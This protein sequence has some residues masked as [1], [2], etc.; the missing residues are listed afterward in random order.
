MKTIADRVRAASVETMRAISCALIVDEAVHRDDVVEFAERRIEHIA[1]GE[2]RGASA[3][4]DGRSFSR[5]SD[6]RRRNIDADDRR[7]PLGELERERACPAAGVE[8]ARAPGG[9][10]AANRESLRASRRA[11]RARSRGRG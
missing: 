4:A 3:R 1:H 9:R 10:A 5:K 6:Q 11:R 7:A 8:N 2:G